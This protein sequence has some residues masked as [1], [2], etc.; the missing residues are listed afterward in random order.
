MSLF[1]HSAVSLFT[2]TMS[3]Y[4]TA[5]VCIVPLVCALDCLVNFIL[6]DPLKFYHN[7][8]FNKNVML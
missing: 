8:G 3:D 4:S 7:K 6:F 2:C 1:L 5:R